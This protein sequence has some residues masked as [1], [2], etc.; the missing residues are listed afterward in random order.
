MPPSLHHLLAVSQRLVFLVDKPRAYLSIEV[1]RGDGCSVSVIDKP[2]R[3]RSLSLLTFTA[4]V[5]NKVVTS[6]I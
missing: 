6:N 1:V 4:H 5:L 2:S 3:L